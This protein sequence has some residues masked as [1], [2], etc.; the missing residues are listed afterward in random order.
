MGSSQRA[1]HATEKNEASSRSHAVC[2]LT[3][4]LNEGRRFRIALLANFELGTK[5]Y[6]ENFPWLTWL[7]VKDHRLNYFLILFILHSD[8]ANHDQDR[9][10]ESISINKSLM[11]LKECIRLNKTCY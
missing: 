11:A 4:I 5:R 8:S 7:G 6:L 3:I 1:T 10:R 2:Q 9:Q